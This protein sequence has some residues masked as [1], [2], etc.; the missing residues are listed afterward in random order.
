MRKATIIRWIVRGLMA[1][2]A[3]AAGVA[4]AA[5][6][7]T[8]YVNDLAGSPIVAMDAGGQV[9]WRESYR[10]YGE[11]LTNSAAASG[12]K[13][14][15]T[16]RRQDAETGLVYMG[17]RYYDPVVGRF[18]STDPMQFDGSDPHTFNRYAY[19]ANNPYKYIDPDGR[20]FKWAYGTTEPFKQQFD[21][22]ERYLNAGGVGGIIAELRNRPEVI[23]LQQGAPGMMEYSPGNRTLTID[24]LSGNKVGEGRI[25]SPALGLLHEA[26]HALQ[27]LTNEA[28]FNSDSKPKSDARYDTKEERRVIERVETPAARKLGEPTRTNHRDGHVPVKCPTCRE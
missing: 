21:A 28:Q 15:F 16:S 14:W 13:I 22:M 17:A 4:Q 1:I 24:P 3:L 23:E 27:H 18:M 19:A 2:S 26:S 5:S 8:Y 9:I 7:V 10:P 11:R 20:V 6:T 25:Q 12:N